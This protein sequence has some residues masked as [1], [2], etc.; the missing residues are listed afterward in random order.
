[1]ILVT[2]TSDQTRQRGYVCMYVC[3]Y[4]WS[5]TY[6]KSKDKPHKTANPARGQLNS[7]KNDIFL[8]PFASENLVSRDEFG[9]P[10]PRQ[11]AHLLTKAKSGAYLRDSSRIP[12]C[13]PFIHLNCHTPS[14]QS[15][16]YRVTQLRT[17]V[18]HFRQFVGTGLVNLKVVPN[19]WCLD[20]SPWTNFYAPL[21]PTPTI[22]MKWACRK[23]PA[24]WRHLIDA[25]I[26]QHF[27]LI[28]YS[29]RWVR[30][31]KNEGRGTV[32][33]AAQP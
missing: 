4:V 18:I 13:P 32:V 6:S 21:F 10:V 28:L 17:D 1:M 3:M 24:R 16:V 27:I 2:K 31:A 25:H 22:C 9:S 26:Q 7:G 14:G 19:G 8:S 20:R 33:R 5:G 11:S 29:R 30:K 23:L 15:R 12:R